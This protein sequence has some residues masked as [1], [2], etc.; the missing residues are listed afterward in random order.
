MGD[1]AVCVGMDEANTAPAPPEGFTQMVRKGE[2]WRMSGPYFERARTGGAEQAF[3]AADKH[4]NAMGFVHGGMLSGFLDGLLFQAV[5]RV[6]GA[7]SAI[8][9]HMSIDFLAAARNGAWVIGEAEV[10]RETAD[11]VFASGRVHSAGRDVARA[12]GLFK[13]TRPAGS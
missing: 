11:V 1:A 3:L 12:S 8:T 5:K 4:C 6:I 9:L 7:Q 13:P 10:T 2:F